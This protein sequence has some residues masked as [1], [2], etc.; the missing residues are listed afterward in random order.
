LTKHPEKLKVLL[1]KKSMEEKMKI[2]EGTI[3]NKKSREIKGEEN[4]FRVDIQIN[5]KYYKT[6]NIEETKGKELQE[7]DKISFDE[8]LVQ[9]FANIGFMIRHFEVIKTSNQNKRGPH[10]T[11]PLIIKNGRGFC[12]C[13][14]SSVFHGNDRKF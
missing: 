4:I 5:G 9:F 8:D 13:T 11:P 10:I 1:E 12:L 2:I 3:S 7:G 14:I 6:Y